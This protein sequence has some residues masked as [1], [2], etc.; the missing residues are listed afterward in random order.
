MCTF[1]TVGVDRRR[2]AALEAS[3][4]AMQLVVTRAVN[5]HVALLFPASHA[6]FLVTQGHCSCGLWVMP[7]NWEARRR[8]Q[9]L[10]RYQRKEYSAAKIARILEGWGP[11]KPVEE[12]PLRL[13]LRAHAP[14]RV[15]LQQ[16]RRDPATERVD[17]RD[18]ELV[19]VA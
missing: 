3:L 17:G 18:V 15:C 7:S 16:V 10:R 4:R 9:R 6:L 14:A 5:P 19:D 13:V 1:L 12:D 2:A 8:D 11:L